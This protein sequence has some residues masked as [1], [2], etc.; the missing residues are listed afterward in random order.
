MKTLGMVEIHDTPKTMPKRIDVLTKENKARLLLQTVRNVADSCIFNSMTESLDRISEGVTPDHNEADSV[1]NYATAV[2]KFGLLRRVS[3]MTTASGDG[4]RALRHWRFALLAYHQARKI[5]YRLESF[6]VNASVKALLPPRFAEEVKWSRFVNLTGG[7][8]KNLDADY[9]LELF[10]NAVKTKLKTLGP[11]HTAKQVMEIS[12]TAMFCDELAKMMSSQLDLAPVSRQ[13]TD[14]EVEKD[15]NLVLNELLQS[16]VFTFTPGRNNSF[17]EKVD[18]F[19][20]INVFD[21]HQWINAKKTHYANGKWA[22]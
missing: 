9:V 2:L 18:V 17:K 8:G 21:L 3:V 7:Q 15:R 12:R 16:N 11:N 13:H 5:K 20:G 22:F 14:R 4:Q 6:L 10:N 1:F 19:S